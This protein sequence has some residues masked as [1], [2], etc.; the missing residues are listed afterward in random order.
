M[1]TIKEVP[2]WE[3]FLNTLLNVKVTPKVFVYL[4]DL[5]SF[6]FLF[7][8]AMKSTFITKIQFEF[9]QYMARVGEALVSLPS[10]MKELVLHY[11]YLF[12]ERVGKLV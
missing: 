11:V 8:T 9:G 1:H 6:K 7:T 2:N 12:F 10:L 3:L 5:K 4:C